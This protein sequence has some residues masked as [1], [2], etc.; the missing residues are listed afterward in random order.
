LWIACFWAAHLLQTED[1]YVRV[2]RV[3]LPLS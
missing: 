2:Y 1:V 3:Y